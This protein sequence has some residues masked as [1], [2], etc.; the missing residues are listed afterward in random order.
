M[1]KF[2]LKFLDIFYPYIYV[3]IQYW[4]LQCVINCITF[5]EK[6]YVMVYLEDAIDQLLEHK[7]EAGKVNV[8]KFFAT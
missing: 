7:D 2:V 8:S 3:C 6:N 5:V 4:T 1:S